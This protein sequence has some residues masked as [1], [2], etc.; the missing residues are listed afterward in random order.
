M[1][2]REPE[3]NKPLETDL[4]KYVPRAEFDEL[5]QRFNTLCDQ[6]GG[7]KHDE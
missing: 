7:A 2:R 4:A 3:I 5:K 1:Y 6:L